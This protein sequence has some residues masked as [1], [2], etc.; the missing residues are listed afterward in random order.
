MSRAIQLAEP[1]QHRLSLPFAGRLIDGHKLSDTDTGERTDFADL[2]DNEGNCV[3]T[4]A[5]GYESINV[6]E[7]DQLIVNRA[8]EPVDGSI[9]LMI[10]DFGNVYLCRHKADGFEY[11]GSSAP[12]LATPNRILGV[13]VAMSRRL[14]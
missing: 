10:D 8:G 5:G 7:G 11:L 1:P 3:L 2:F 6:L 12:G 13:V 14:E 4:V 9:I